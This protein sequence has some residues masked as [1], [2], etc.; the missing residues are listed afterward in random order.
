MKK[1]FVTAAVVVAGFGFTACSSDDDNSQADNNLRVGD[2][3]AV[4]LSYIRPDTGETHT[5]PFSMITG[6]CDVDDLELRQNNTVDLET[7]SKVDEVCVEAHIAG[8]WNDT[9][10]TVEGEETA[11]EIISVTSTELVLKYT[12][13]YGG[14]GTTEVTVRYIKS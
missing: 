11:R 12:M 1:F 8:S 2:W 3:K 5:L 10:V 4:E 13:T 7:E 9:S 6:G 14:F